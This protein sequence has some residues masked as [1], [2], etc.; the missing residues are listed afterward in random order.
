GTDGRLEGHR[1]IEVAPGV[2]GRARRRDR[3]EAGVLV[4]QP[5]E[6]RGLVEPREAEPVDRAAPAHESGRVAVGEE[7]VLRD[8]RICHG[9]VL[10]ESLTPETLIGPPG[11]TWP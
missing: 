4:E 10:R 11:A 2:L 7:R 8:R 1:P 5:G 9:L 6:H 3:P